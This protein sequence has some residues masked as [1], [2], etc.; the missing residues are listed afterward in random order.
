[1]HLDVNAVAGTLQREVANRV[2]AMIAYLAESLNL[3]E[4]EQAAWIAAA[5][6]HLDGVEAAFARELRRELGG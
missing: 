5:L 2:A 6:Q 1:V 4:K 3:S